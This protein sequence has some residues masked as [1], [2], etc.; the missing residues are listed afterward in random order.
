[1]RE[2]FT[3]LLVYRTL[4]FV[5]YIMGSCDPTLYIHIEKRFPIQVF[6]IKFEPCN[7]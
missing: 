5:I 6:L 4:T 7:I 1:M 2:A 3:M